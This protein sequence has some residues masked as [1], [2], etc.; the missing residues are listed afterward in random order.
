MVH[1]SI[2]ILQA[3][4]Q[5]L[6]T[7]NETSTQ[8][9]NT[10]KGSFADTVRFIEQS[11]Q[12]VALELV[13]QGKIAIYYFAIPLEGYTQMM[14]NPNVQIYDRTAG[15]F[16]LLLNPAPVTT[17]VF[18]THF[19]LG[20]VRYAMNFLVDREFVVDEILKGYG[21]GMIDPFGQYSPEYLN[22]IDTV[23]SFGIKYNPALAEKMIENALTRVGA[24]KDET[25]GKWFFAGKPITLK[26]LIRNDDPRR[27]SLGDLVSSE[28][29]RIGFTVKNLRRS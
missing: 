13:K 20:R 10:T 9:N 22:L 29:E 2:S 15:S 1:P 4:C 18:L 23:E 21:S 17:V 7:N 27:K 5:S 3:S 6:G 11:N 26:I 12:N 16:G 19:R 8:Y 28:L 25:T 14:N 24:V